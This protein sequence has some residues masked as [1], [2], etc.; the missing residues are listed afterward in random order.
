M[1]RNQNSAQEN[2]ERHARRIDPIQPAHTDCY[3]RLRVVPLSEH[4]GEWK[5]SLL[6]KLPQQETRPLPK[7]SSVLTS[8]PWASF[9]LMDEL[10]ITFDAS[11]A[12]SLITLPANDLLGKYVPF[13]CR[14]DEHKRG[15][16]EEAI[17]PA[18]R[19]AAVVSGSGWIRYP[20]SQVQQLRTRRI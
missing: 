5:T 10:P 7:R 17:G 6:K 20:E 1:V 16:I 2:P 15:R 14:T 9:P 4:T 18:C 11:E 12:I 13:V 3:Q 19:H 8:H